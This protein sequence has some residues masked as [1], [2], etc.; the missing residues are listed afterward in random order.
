MDGGKC[1]GTL[2]IH[3]CLFCLIQVCSLLDTVFEKK[4][5]FKTVQNGIQAAQVTN[6]KIH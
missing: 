2:S 5:L 3:A 1:R 6:V 4:G